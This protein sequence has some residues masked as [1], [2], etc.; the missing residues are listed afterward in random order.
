MTIPAILD[1][2]T[3]RSDLLQGAGTEADFAADGAAV[4]WSTV[5]A[6]AGPPVERVT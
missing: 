5:A 4:V 2:C 3:P 6:D 1:T